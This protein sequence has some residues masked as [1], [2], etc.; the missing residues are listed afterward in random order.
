MEDDVLRAIPAVH[1][2]ID[3]AAIAAYRPLLGASA[4]KSCV[5]DVLEAARA[6]ARSGGTPHFDILRDRVLSALAAREASGLIGV[7][8]ATGVLLHTNFGR[9]PLAGAALDAVAMLGAGYTNLEFDLESGERGSR[10]E[11]VASQLC[12]LSGAQAALVVNNCA[13]AVLLVLD[14]FA[15]GREVVVSRGQ[16]IEIGGAFRLPDVLRKSGATLVEVGTTN[17]TYGADYR[18]AWTDRAAIFM[19]SHPSNYRV[20]GFTAEV[21]AGSM[22]AIARELGVL[23]FEDLGSGALVDLSPYGLPH[24]PTLA[25]EIAVGVDLVAVSGDKLLG[26][27]QCGIIA[28]RSGLI[29]TLRR[30][31]LLRALRVDKMTLAALSATLALYVEPGRLHEIP[32]F[33]MLETPLDDLIKRADAICEAAQSSPKVQVDAR[34][35]TSAVGGGSLPTTTIPS[36]GVALTARDAGVDELA[37]RL[38]SGRP[39]IVGRADGDSIVLDLRTVRPSEDAAVVAAIVSCAA[40]E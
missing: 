34:A 3:D 15:R 22:A 24:E 20:E 16:L 5:N 11:R 35:T 25:E 13:A 19:R 32:F 37:S 23:S 31:P 14:T 26:G 27:P 10:Y 36:A 7:I 28:G 17:R 6:A 12:D 38:R 33:A 4:V 30:N 21:D 40:C 2:F 9:A 1:R 29:D 8:N 18:D 39:P